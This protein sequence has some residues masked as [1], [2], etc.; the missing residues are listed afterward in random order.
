MSEVYV[1]GIGMTPFGR[2]PDQSVKSLTAA[3]VTEALQDAGLAQAD[4]G[5]A[6]FGNAT[7]SPLEG[8]FMVPGQIALREIGFERTPITNVEN[9]C[10]SSSTALQL[11]YANVKAGISDFALAIG[12]EKMCFADKSKGFG[13]FDGAW[14]VT[15]AAETAAGLERLGEGVEPPAGR[16]TPANQRSLF[17][18]VYANLAKYHMKTYG[19]TERQLAAVAAKN[20]CHAVHN[21]L[22]QYRMAMSVDDVLA[23]R[24]I[25]WPLTI[26][27]CAPIS[28]G[29]AAM[30]V[31]NEDGLKRLGLDSRA[32]ERAVEVRACIVGGG[33][34]RAPEN[35]EE[36][37]ARLAADRAYQVAGLGPEDMSL[38][39]VHD[40]SSFAE[41]QQTEN[42]GFCEYGQGGWL[43]ERGETSLG[44]RIPI[45][46]SGGLE[47]KGHPIGATGLGQIHELV[48]QLRREAGPRQV[49]GARFAIAENGGGFYR[50]EEAVACITILGR[51]DA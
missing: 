17:M 29:A 40:A 33:T 44:G 4:I 2:Q 27:M 30:V 31:C 14:D 49:E 18:D 34:N 45:N 50:C 39:E 41:V 8:Q 11:A 20:H 37:I 26:A 15:R 21:P 38:A 5:A 3:A 46:T 36:Q 16:A 43:A 23:A 28:D 24:M 19:T 13:V 48:T 42:L 22:A 12:A 51:R 25:V 1:V 10:A 7:Q 35:L 9:A 32:A 47:C 6:F